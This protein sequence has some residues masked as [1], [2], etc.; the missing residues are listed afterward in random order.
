MRLKNEIYERPNDG[1]VRSAETRQQTAA[2]LKRKRN[3]KLFGWTAA[4]VVLFVLLFNVVLLPL[5][6]EIA[7]VKDMDEY[8]GDNK[9]II[10]GNQKMML[11]AHRAGGDLA[12]EETML[13][14]EKCMTAADYA[15]DIVEFDL[16]LTKDNQLVLLHDDTA[17]RTSNSAEIFGEEVEVIDLTL[18][19]LKTLNF[20][21]N[22][23]AADGSYPY[24][25][26]RGA[27][28]PEDVKI[29]TLDEIL[30][31]L[32]SVRG[33]N[34]DYIIEI[35]NE[36]GDGER[37]MDL[38]YAKMVEYG[39]VDNTIVGTFNGNV[40]KHIDK[41]Y[42]ELTRSSG[43]SEVLSFYYAF[44]YGA[45]L[46]KRDLN[47]TVLQ[48]PTGYAMFDL[49]TKALIDYAHKY[50]LAVQYWTINDADEIKRLMEA[51]AD[52]VMTDNPEIA[53]AVING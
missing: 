4:G 5:T 32:K 49:G 35:K 1:R 13:A 36:G 8:D 25:G 40:S 18:A 21:E 38:L 42:P 39:I 28:I 48:I 3:K 7:R 46:S 23:K 44:L 53:Y 47:Y 24:R 27:D 12:P 9:Y 41:N 14:F 30:T 10:G 11:S 2:R 50:G 37:A 52:A 6:S 22:F 20:G 33:D 16:H 17:D 19:E 31:Y 15:V 51:G 29:L 26:K 43:I 45:D 34:L